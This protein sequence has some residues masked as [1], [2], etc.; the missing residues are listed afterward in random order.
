[1]NLNLDFIKPNQVTFFRIAAVPLIAL[2]L[3]L[4]GGL[5]GVLAT[6][7]YILAALSDWFDGYLARK[8]NDTS[9]LGQVFD[10]MADKLLVVGCL[11]GLAYNGRLGGAIIPALAIVLREI[12]IMGLREY[13]ARKGETSTAESAPLAVT[14]LAKTKT[15]IELVAIGLLVAVP[16]PLPLVFG[17]IGSFLLWVAAGLSL[18]TGYQY[19]QQARFSPAKTGT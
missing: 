6:L 4:K 2:L 7:L 12:F 13:A 11:L 17:I 14:K 3:C 15:A 8:Y 5:W 1:M 16:F 18:H 10:V 19:F 9:L